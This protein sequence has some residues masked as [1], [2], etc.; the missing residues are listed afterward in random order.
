MPI[1]AYAFTAAQVV[2]ICVSS[3]VDLDHVLLGPSKLLLL[4]LSAGC[5]GVKKVGEN[6]R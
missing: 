1:M 5:E 6:K 2:V 3:L 4:F